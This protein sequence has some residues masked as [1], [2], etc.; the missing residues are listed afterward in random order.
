MSQVSGLLF[1]CMIVVKLHKYLYIISSPGRIKAEKTPFPKK[2]LVG[3]WH[4]QVR[5]YNQYAHSSIIFQFFL[6]ESYE[7]MG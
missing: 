3:K 2:E 6:N 5:Q 1:I 7:L 4:T